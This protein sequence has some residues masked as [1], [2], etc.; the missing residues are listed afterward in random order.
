MANEAQ[1]KA[2]PYLPLKTFLSALDALREGVPKRIDRAIW[3]SQSGAVQAQIVVAFR[4]FGLLDDADA[5]TLPLLEKLTRADESERKKLLKPLVEQRYQPII[6][7]DLTK[8][9][10]GMLRDEMEKFGVSGDTLRKAITFFLQIAKH[11]DLP[12]SPYLKDRTR[13]SSPR[14]RRPS[15]G[16]S[17]TPPS[18]GTPP[19][20]QAPTAG[21]STSVKLHGGGEIM[22]IVTADVWKMP[23]NDRTFVLDLIDKIQGY[24]KAL[25][26]ARPK[27]KVVGQ[28]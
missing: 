19:A 17:A 13:A 8:M 27:E 2:A 26:P 9:T 10:P 6:A 20:V 7:H 28:S 24:E 22:M 5:P 25:L 16:Q 4:F 12:L 14:T 15:R 3:R 18:N 23:S 1:V 21:S 11:L